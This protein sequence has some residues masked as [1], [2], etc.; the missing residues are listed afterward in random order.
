MQ[1]ISANN[2]IVNVKIFFIFSFFMML[3]DFRI[4]FPIFFDFFRVL[5]QVMDDIPNMIQ[6]GMMFFQVYGTFSVPDKGL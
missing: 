1:V 3:L 6:N 2:M 4:V 5:L